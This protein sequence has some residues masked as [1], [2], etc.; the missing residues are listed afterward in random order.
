MMKYI[1]FGSGKKNYV[2]IPG[3]SVHS[4]LGLWKAIEESHRAFTK[5]YTVYLFDR[6]EVLN[7]GCT[8]REIARCTAEAMAD[9]NL[10]TADVFGASMG[11]M[12][13]Q[14]IAID[15]PKL[16]HKLILGSTCAK[17]GGTARQVIREWMNLAKAHREEDLLESFVDKVY[18]QNTLAVHRQALILGNRGIR[19]AEYQRFIIQ[20]NACLDFD[21]SEELHKIQ[22]PTLVLG[23]KGDQVLTEVGSQQIA[24]VLHCEMYLYDEPYGHGVYD[25]APDYKARCLEFLGR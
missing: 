20:S 7:P 9:L 6:P 8:I 17:P 1:R 19:P 18:S 21:S 15:H 12:I 11:G 24:E 16:V 4:V 22:C 23:S 14:Y 5:E 2:I 10:V 25:E 3:L 13:A